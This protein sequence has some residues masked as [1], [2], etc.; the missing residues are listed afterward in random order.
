MGKLSSQ[1]IQSCSSMREV[2]QMQCTG[3]SMCKPLSH[4]GQGDKWITKWFF[5]KKALLHK[6]DKEA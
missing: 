6:K 2:Y 1:G 4:L 3:R 5:L